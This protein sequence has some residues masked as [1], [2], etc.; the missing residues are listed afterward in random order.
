MLFKSIRLSSYFFDLE[1]EIKN[2]ALWVISN[3]EVD[4]RS[5]FLLFDNF[6]KDFFIEEESNV[7]SNDLFEENTMGLWVLLALFSGDK[8]SVT[9]QRGTN[10]FRYL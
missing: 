9:T 7:S 10:G 1:G 4:V 3:S 5:I 6:F 2:T 8:I